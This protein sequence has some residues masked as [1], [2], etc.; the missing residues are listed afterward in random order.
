[1]IVLFFIEIVALLAVTAWSVRFFLKQFRAQRAD[2]GEVRR[3]L[4]VRIPITAV[5]IVL[6]AWAIST[7]SV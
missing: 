6:G 2:G 4:S 7:Q 5:I 1:M 3:H